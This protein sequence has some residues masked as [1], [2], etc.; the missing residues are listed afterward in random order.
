MKVVSV[1]R[2]KDGTAVLALFLSERERMALMRAGM[3][4]AAARA[5]MKVAVLS[6]EAAAMFPKARRVEIS[7]ADADAFVGMAVVD[8]LR[9]GIEESRRRSRS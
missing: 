7:D 9:R 3:R 6:P 5:R 1:R 2:R 4:L 8:A